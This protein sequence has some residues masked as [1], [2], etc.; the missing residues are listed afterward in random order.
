MQLEPWDEW[1]RALVDQVHPPQWE[2]PR[3]SGK[4]NL[5][6][7]G[8]GSAGLISSLATAGLGGKAAL[9]ERH[10]LGG[11]CLNHGCVPSKAL[12]RAARAVHDARQAEHFGCR[13]TAPC[14]V[15]FAEVAA[16]LRR[17]RASIAR[18]DAAHRLRQLGVDVFLGNA[19]L[20]GPDRLRV[21]AQVLEFHRAVIATGARPAV[22]PIEGLAESG[23]LTNETIFSLTELPG[24]LVVLG[25]GPI[26]CELAQ[27]FARLGSQVSLVGR[28]AR[29]LPKEDPQASDVVAAQFRQEGIAL[30][31][32]CQVERVARVGSQIEVEG[33]AGAQRVQ[34]VGDTLLVAVGRQPNVES[35]GL[36]AAQVR[37]SA[38]GVEV[39]DYL[40]TSNPRIYAAGDVASRFQFTHAA[41]A[42]ARIAVRNA[43]F[44][45]RQRASRLVIPRCTYTDPEVAHVGLTPAEAVANGVH[46]A[47]FRVPLT[48][49]DRAVLDGETA[50]FA[51]LHTRPGRGQVLGATLVARHAG[52]MIGEIT[53]LLTKRWKISALAQTIHC[54][55]TQAE[56]WK[57]L[58]D[59]HARTRL[60]PRVARLFSFWLAR[61]R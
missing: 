48:D 22:P 7:I 53:L 14:E 11:D 27:A 54:Y 39:D 52:E 17:L 6:A 13:L 28:D 20:I 45:G 19:E 10:L 37:R 2:N 5:V 8:G 33:R 15:D 55:P 58:A 12:L 18:H 43:L 40:R 34:V 41:D 50:G 51:V 49:I 35:L 47:S 16:R 36:E 56:V 4:Y 42:L 32:G 46:L 3:P 44:W 25:G 57:R 31:L 23:Y 1:N 30:H 38:G 61:Q 59:A 24:R 21:G 60:T 9:I 29:L 26:G